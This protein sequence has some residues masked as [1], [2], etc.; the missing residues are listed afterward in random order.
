MSFWNKP[1]GEVPPRVAHCRLSE[2]PV[3]GL[4]VAKD[5]AFYDFAPGKFEY[6]YAGINNLVSGGG[7]AE[8][9][10]SMS[11]RVCEPGSDLFVFG[12][13]LFDLIVK[14][15]KRSAD[16]THVMPEVRDSVYRGAD[17]AAKSDV[18]GNEFFERR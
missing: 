15:R 2:L 10:S 7:K 17:R 1:R 13:K 12:D 4:G 14:I 3:Q 11:S 5:I 8:Q 18:R 6:S 9:F 16:F